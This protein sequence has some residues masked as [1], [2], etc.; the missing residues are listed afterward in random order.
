MSHARSRA[1]HNNAGG[2]WT[3]G[4]GDGWMGGVLTLDAYAAELT[5]LHN[6]ACQVGSKVDPSSSCCTSGEAACMPLTPPLNVKTSK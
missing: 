1:P 2:G 6:K 5:L 4:M 3:G